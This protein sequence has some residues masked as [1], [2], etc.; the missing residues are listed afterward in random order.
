MCCILKRKKC[1]HNASCVAHW[2][3]H[4]DTQE[5]AVHWDY[6]WKTDTGIHR[7]AVRSQIQELISELRGWSGVMDRDASIWHNTTDFSVLMKRVLF[8]PTKQSWSGQ[9]GLNQHL[10][11]GPRL[12]VGASHY[13]T[14][15]PALQCQSWT[16]AFEY[17]TQT[18]SQ[19]SRAAVKVRALP[20]AP[21]SQPASE[22]DICSCIGTMI[23]WHCTTGS[24][25]PLA[26][27][28]SACVSFW[29]MYSEGN[30][31]F[32]WVL[33]PDGVFSFVY[34]RRQ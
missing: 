18:M 21:S 7:T 24:H 26:L 27:K 9:K 31:G 14:P 5:H 25:P 17:R 22:L 30:E 20:V 11:S 32:S 15:H 10:G 1:I 19:N 34:C 12:D 2:Q 29:G 23:A 4:D 13:L 6:R 33:Q 8:V 16:C 3:W 28:T